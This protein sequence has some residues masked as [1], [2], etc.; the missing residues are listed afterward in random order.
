VRFDHVRTDQV[1]GT[2]SDMLA[3]P[4]R[5]AE[6]G[7]PPG[8]CVSSAGTGR[9]AHTLRR[10]W[11][12][13]RRSTLGS[14]A[15][16]CLVWVGLSEG[17]RRTRRQPRAPPRRQQATRTRSAVWVASGSRSFVGLGEGEPPAT[18]VAGV[19]R[20]R[21]SDR[22]RCCPRCRR[23][24]VT[25]RLTGTPTVC[26]APGCIVT[27]RRVIRVSTEMVGFEKREG[28]A[29]RRPTSSVLIVRDAASG[30]TS[31]GRVRPTR[32]HRPR[33]GPL[34]RSGPGWR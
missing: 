25:R 11:L 16:P 26:P 32:C 5:D 20:K 12:S 6:S 30:R 13:V 14:F 18:V 33:R 10:G 24:V 19:R 1:F 15:R 2:P 28:R 23:S 17:A 4:V 8:P 31:T 7:V 34:R 22:C 27:T 21:V 3:G 9:P 29:C